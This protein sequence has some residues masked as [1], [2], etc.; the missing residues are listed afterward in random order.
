[1]KTNVILF[2]IF[3]GFISYGF[4][5]FKFGKINSTKKNGNGCVCH[6]ISPA[7]DV[8]V[9]VDGPDS[10]EAGKSQ[11]YKMYMI[12]GPAVAGGYNVAVSEG[13]LSLADTNSILI[14]N[15]ITQSSPLPFLGDTVHW[16]FIYTAPDSPNSFDTLYSTGLSVNFD[17]IPNEFDLW[18]YG[19]NFVVKII[20]TNSVTSSRSQIIPEN[21]SLSQNYPNPFNPTT[22][23]SYSV[24]ITSSVRLDVFDTRGKL[25]L[26]LENGIKSTGSYNVKLNGVALSSGVYL[27]KLT[28]FSTDG[29]TKQLF[30]QTKKLLLIK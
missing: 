21:F 17:G 3:L 18:A 23:I 10:V 8:I 22:I 30:T 1:M 13:L 26:N 28:A 9:W 24:G 29:L 11:V 5:V 27:Y 15:E 12:G 7:E 14:E 2:A 6:N 25:I 4:A 19:D 16:S 20:D